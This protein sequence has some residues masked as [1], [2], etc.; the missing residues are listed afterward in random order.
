MTR[1]KVSGLLTA[2]LAAAVLVWTAVTL[3]PARVVLR[4]SAPDPGSRVYVSG[5]FHVHTRNSDGTGSP[6]EIAAAAARAGLKFVVFAD[7][8]DGIRVPDRPTYRAGVLCI[9]AV[10]ISTTGGHYIALG[11]PETPF[12]LAGEPRDVADD[13]ARFGGFGIVAHPGSTKRALRWRDWDLRFDGVEWLNAD[14]EWRDETRRRLLR[15]LLQYPFRHAETLAWLLDRPHAVLRQWDALT[16]TRRVVALAG[17]DAHARLGFRGRSDPYEEGAALEWPSYETTFRTFSIRVGLEAPFA[18]RAE[19]DARLLLDGIRGGRAY[20]AVDALA[21][22]AELRFR[23]RHGQAWADMGDLL[24]ATGP[25]RLLAA[26]NGPAGSRMTLF[27]DGKAVSS[28]PTIEFDAGEPGAYRV[29][30]TVPDSPGAPPVPWILSNPIYVGLRAPEPMTAAAAKAPASLR[31]LLDPA[32]VSPWNTEHDAMSRAAVQTTTARTGAELATTFA[33][34]KTR[35]GSP[36]AALTRTVRG[37]L[38]GFDQLTFEVR[39]LRPMR[40][41]V[42]LRAPLEPEDARWQRSVF[43]GAEAAVATVRFDDMRPIGRDTPALPSPENVDFLLFV[44]DTVNTRPGTSGAF[45]LRNVRLE[46]R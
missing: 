38:E 7:H 19:R 16:R 27:R 9:D 21:A 40:L 1:W 39:A 34:A 45:W 12:P 33:L 37:Q 30:V 17:T 46:K 43:V 11:M 25:V 20:S 44:V 14:S 42:Q 35:A 10:E 23:A 2:A 3:P 18:G 5:A 24:P 41:S 36:W 15:A 4:E 13:V 26:S 32:D 8:G 28:G 31:L 22:P 6:D 29:E